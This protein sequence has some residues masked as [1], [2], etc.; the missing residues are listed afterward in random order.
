MTQKIDLEE[1]IKALDSPQVKRT[2]TPKDYE[3]IKKGA[4]A[5]QL[6]HRV[7][8]RDAL[9]Y[10]ITTEVTELKIQLEQAEKIANG[11]K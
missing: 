6:K 10:S 2:R 1:E 8:L 3:A 11:A 7:A 5:L 9:N 4:L